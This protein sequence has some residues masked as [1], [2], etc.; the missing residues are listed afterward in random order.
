MLKGLVLTLGLVLALGG[1]A[2]SDEPGANSPSPTGSDRD[3][4]GCIGSAGYAWCERTS[5]CERPFE[6][7]PK[8]GFENT[9]EQFKAYCAG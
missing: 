4:H 5:R 7:A 2:T 9:P 3:A 8:A 6:L 1:C